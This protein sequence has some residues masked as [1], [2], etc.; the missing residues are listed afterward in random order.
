M[1][2]KIN[3]YCLFL[4]MPLLMN[5]QGKIDRTPHPYIENPNMIQENKMDTRVHFGVFDTYPEAKTNTFEKSK[6]Y[7]SLNGIWKFNYAENPDK[8]PVDFYK[9]DFDVSAWNDI[10]VP[11]NWEVEG[12][13]TP[14][15]TNHPHEFA[16]WRNDDYTDLR[17]AQPPYVP[18]E[19]NPVGSYKRT[20]D[21]P[22]NWKGKDVILHIGAI[23]SAAFI[24]VNGERVG[25]TQG[26]KLPSEFNITKYLK[27]GKNNVAFEVYRWSDASYL[28]CQD[29]WRLS[30]IERDVYLIAQPKVAV[31]DIKITSGLTNQYKDG[32]FQ[33]SVNLINTTDVDQ[34]ASVKYQLFELETGEE[35]QKDNKSVSLSKGQFDV[36]FE[37]KEFKDIKAWSAEAPNLYQAIITLSDVNDKVLMSTSQRLGFKSSEIKDGK[38]LV[39]GQPVLLK[40][41]NLHEHNAETGHVMTKELMRKDLELMKQFNVNAV[42]TSHYPQPEYWYD[43]CDE[44]GIYVL[45]EANIE[46]HGMGYNLAK[47]RSLGNTPSYE[48]AHVDRIRRMYQRDK[49][50]VSVIGWSLGNE[51]GNGYNFYKG[52]QYLK[53][54][55]DRPVQYERAGLEWNTDIYVPMYPSVGYIEKY[56][57]EYSDRPLIMCEY[58][59]SMGNSTGNMKDYWDVIEKYENLQGGFIW[60]WVDQ[61]IKVEKDGK[62]MYAFG[63]DFGPEN[64]PTD[65]NFLLNGVVNSDRTPQPALYE[66][67]KQYQ[68]VKFEAVDLEK[69]IVRVKNWNY[70]IDLSKYHLEI[71]VTADGK[72]VKRFPSQ[73]LK[74]KPT[75]TEELTFDVSAIKPLANTE[76]YLNL[77]LQLINEEPF[78]PKNFEVAK[79]QFLLPIYKNEEKPLPIYAGLT[80]DENDAE[81]IIKNRWLHLVFD[82]KE[83]IIKEYTVNKVAYL[84]DGKGP[85]PTFWR[86]IVDNDY[87]NK[88]DV[89]NINWKKATYE[90]KV[91]NVSSEMLNK[92]TASIQVTFDLGEI[93]TSCNVNYLVNGDGSIDVKATLEGKEDLPDLPRFGMVM[94]LQKQFDQFT[95]YGKGPFENYIDRNDGASVSVYSSK[96]KDQFVAY[97][98][99]QE[100][101]H[102]TDVQWAA[103]ANSKGNALMFKS[104]M[105]LGTTALHYTSEDLDARPGY[106][107]PEVRLE[108]K[109]NCDI[110]AQDLVEW[111]IDYKQRGVAGTDSWYSMPLDQYVI[112]PNENITYEFTLVPIKSASVNKY[113]QT[114]K[115]KYKRLSI[116]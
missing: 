65:G 94:Q 12:F 93:G 50:Y 18:Q 62:I 116:Q 102:K 57:K 89:K 92:G 66:V 111:H 80:L 86:P 63:G 51:A 16:D 7:L 6:N 11:S 108:N 23:K 69:G 35:I 87:G 77:S 3:L 49:N 4:L 5:A 27:E 29:F 74:T 36:A 56:A 113:I 90:S 53:S 28:E 17:K 25:Y 43:L 83:G 41:V 78:L 106:K 59:H 39:N 38:L 47:G 48:L 95:Y 112:Q 40:G 22:A 8:R 13:G 52:Y 26:S 107:Y 55:D 19:K 24:F 21:I 82:K 100:N 81:L 68:N 101:G 9:N 2:K 46:S 31:N 109:H 20:F 45:D 30:G 61:G 60:D 115:K 98:R 34:K 105:K 103:L 75:E 70:F 110:E 15:Y 91:S 96:V 67:K 73:I 99:P 44:Y 54:V 42:R 72:V 1:T 10:K 58:E 79:E 85:K 32:Q 88:M 97:E 71:T 37:K 104:S 76:Y 84:K 64:V 14:I 33:L 114:A